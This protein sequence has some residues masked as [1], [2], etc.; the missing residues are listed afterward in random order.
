MP[1]RRRL[2]RVLG[3]ALLTCLGCPL[4]HGDYPDRSCSKNEDCFRSQ[5]EHC[6][7]M[8]RQCEGAAID[9]AVDRTPDANPGADG[10][11]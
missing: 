1:P 5:G 6:N 9:A 8:T 7:L 10:G 11:L 4:S 2:F 3:L